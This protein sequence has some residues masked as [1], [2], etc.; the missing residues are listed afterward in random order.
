M[1]KKNPT[2]PAINISFKKTSQGYRVVPNEPFQLF[3]TKKIIRSIYRRIS[4]LLSQPIS[5]KCPL[6]TLKGQATMAEWLQEPSY[7]LLLM[8]HFQ[9][10]PIGSTKIPSIKSKN[11]TSLSTFDRRFK[12]IPFPFQSKMPTFTSII[13]I[14]WF[15][16]GGKMLKNISHHHCV[17]KTFWVM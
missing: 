11:N 3:T 17:E 8:L 2:R 15:P 7:N 4:L 16:C 9:L 6:S 13:E 1:F 10:F 14:L 12:A 5:S